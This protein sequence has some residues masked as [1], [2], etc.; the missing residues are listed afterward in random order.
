[1]VALLRSLRYRMT[2]AE[3]LTWD[4]GD[5]SVHAWQL[6]DGEPVAMAP[7]SDNHGTIQW[8]LGSLLWPHLTVPGSRCRAA[9]EPGVVP[10]GHSDRNYRVPDIGVTCAPPSDGQMLP[11]PLILIEILSP[12]NEAEAWANVWAYLTIPTVMEVLVVNSTLMEAELLHR[13]ADGTW[14]EVPQRLGPDDALV[15]ESIGFSVPLAALY[16]TTTLAMPGGNP[17]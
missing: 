9:M 10:R 7:A 1:M 5:R 16:R 12:S 17:P 4:S 6:I 8:A 2:V 11:D 14:P 15:L 13:N 3:F